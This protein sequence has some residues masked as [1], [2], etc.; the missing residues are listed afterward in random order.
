MGV[1]G[2]VGE[3]VF[4]VGQ[5]R[6]SK[7]GA[8]TGDAL[9][10]EEAAFGIDEP[11]LAFVLLGAKKP[12][13]FSSGLFLQPPYWSRSSGPGCAASSIASSCLRTT[14]SSTD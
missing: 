14:R 8:D 3:P 4:A 6:V 7:A 13:A 9:R 5:R 12:L 2:Q 1:F 11:P 10:P